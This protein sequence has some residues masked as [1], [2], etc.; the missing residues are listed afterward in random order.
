MFKIGQYVTRKKYNNDVVFKV[1]D[2][3]DNIV[4][5]KGVE[6]RLLA[7]AFENDLVECQYCKKKEEIKRCRELDINNYFY[8]PGIIL[9]IDTDDDYKEKCEEYYDEQKI[10][11]YAYS[12]N[13]KEFKKNII[14]L[15]EKHTPDI[16][17]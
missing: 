13:I 10:R 3:K 16:V 15:I 5:L 2:I 12:F 4:F 7:D 9:H 6:V 1:I 17:I 11:Y 14:K 8:I